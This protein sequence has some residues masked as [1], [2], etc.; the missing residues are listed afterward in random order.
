MIV[1]HGLDVRVKKMNHNGYL[2]KCGDSEKS[3]KRQSLVR[4][5]KADDNVLSF[6]KVRIKANA[7]F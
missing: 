3:L 4:I 5:A 1:S 7:I 6:R 2:R